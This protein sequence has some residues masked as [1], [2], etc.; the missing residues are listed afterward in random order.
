[1]IC[2]SDFLGY[3]RFQTTAAAELELGN[4]QVLLQQ[5]VLL[6]CCWYALNLLC[7]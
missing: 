7:W 4:K 3:C 5:Q 6:S 1:M 2:H